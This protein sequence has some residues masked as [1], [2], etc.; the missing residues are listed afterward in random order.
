MGLF[1]KKLPASR[2]L[3]AVAAS[4][5]LV[6]LD[7]LGSTNDALAVC[8]L[9]S[10]HLCEA[11]EGLG[12]SPDAM[13]RFDELVWVTVCRHRPFLSSV[14]VTF[15]L[16]YL[17][18]HSLIRQTG[19]QSIIE[20]FYEDVALLRGHAWAIEYEHYRMLVETVLRAALNMVLQ[21]KRE[22]K[23]EVA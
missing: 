2:G 9:V 8:A 20:A 11:S 19:D 18:A 16:Y 6:I 10:R 13:E 1:G 5:C 15:S 21:H 14:G 22:W 12:A 23:R 3:A 17:K 4:N 7:K